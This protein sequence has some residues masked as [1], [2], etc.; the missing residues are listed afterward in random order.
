[1][2]VTYRTG[3]MTSLGHYPPEDQELEFD[4]IEAAQ[5]RGKDDYIEYL[6][7]DELDHQELIW[8]RVDGAHWELCEYGHGGTGYYVREVIS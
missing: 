7:N 3:V 4:Q 2:T 5:E 1:M 6:A 8:D